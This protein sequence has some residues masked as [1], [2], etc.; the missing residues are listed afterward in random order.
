MTKKELLELLERLENNTYYSY[1]SNFKLISKLLRDYDEDA[2]ELEAITVNI[3][4][5]VI[6]LLLDCFTTSE[7]VDWLEHYN[8]NIFNNIHH[9]EIKEYDEFGEGELQEILDNGDYVFNDEDEKIII[10]SW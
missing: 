5:Q 3:A 10:I 4:N 2:K 1:N 8:W 7:L 6:D 9:S